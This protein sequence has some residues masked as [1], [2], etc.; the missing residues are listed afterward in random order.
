VR[1]KL[2]L[3]EGYQKLYKFNEAIKIYEEFMK[4][5]KSSN[6]WREEQSE[7]YYNMGQIYSEQYNLEKAKEC[8]VQA[9]GIK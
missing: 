9:I 6:S 7:A 5:A 8:Y 4:E 2:I 3:A 1:V